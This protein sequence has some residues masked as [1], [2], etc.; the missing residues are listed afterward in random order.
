MR[1]ASADAFRT[2]LE[3]RLLTLAEQSD[4]PLVRLRKLV[5]FERLLACLMI[6]APG[7]WILKDAVALHFRAGSRFRT[8]RDLKLGRYDDEQAATR[9]FHLAQ[10]VELSDYFTF[11]IQRTGKLDA[12]LEG[13]AVRYHVTAAVDRR[14]FEQVT[15][16]VG[17]GEPTTLRPEMLR[18]PDLLS[19][20][21]ILAAEVP[22]LPLE[23]RV[24]EKVHAYTRTY[25]SGRPSTRVKDLVDL[26]LIPSSFPFGGARLRSA[27]RETFGARSIHPLPA[28]LPSPPAEWRPGDRRMAAEVGLEGDLSVGY[29]QARTFLDPVLTG[30]ISDQARWDPAQR[31]W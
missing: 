19:F 8:T 20:A 27:L 24:A 15:I 2:A 30:T 4:V 3:R 22:T 16:D 10:S 11:A 28:A 1:Y 25:P 6:V 9:D 18:G 5:V 13:A 26:V 7:R 12:L 29:K 14:P 21:D 23:L 31:T 17:F